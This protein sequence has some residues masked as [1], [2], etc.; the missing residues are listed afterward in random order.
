M[1]SADCHYNREGE[2]GIHGAQ[3]ED[4]EEEEEA[5]DEGVSGASL[6]SHRSS[7]VDEAAEDAEFEQKINRLMAAKQKLRQLQDLVA[8]VQVNTD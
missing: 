6:T 4:D 2:Q 1:L 8:M 5:E 3:G 7:L